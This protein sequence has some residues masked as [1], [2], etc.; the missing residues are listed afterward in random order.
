[1]M[2]KAQ[3]YMWLHTAASKSTAGNKTRPFPC[4]FQVSTGSDVTLDGAFLNDHVVACSTALRSATEE[5][6]SGSN[7]TVSCLSKA[8]RHSSTR[9][10]L[11]F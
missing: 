8:T 9:D 7:V 10:W 1:M 2:D 6:Q 5:N 3:V 4:P 11:K